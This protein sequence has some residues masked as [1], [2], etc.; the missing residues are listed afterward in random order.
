M[1]GLQLLMVIMDFGLLIMVTMM[2]LIMVVLLLDIGMLLQCINI[3]AR[4]HW[5]RMSSFGD[6]NAWRAYAGSKGESKPTPPKPTPKPQPKEEYYTVQSGRLSGEYHKVWNQF[7]RSLFIESSD[8]KSR[9]N[10]SRSES[11]G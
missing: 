2:V 9:P 5:I 7:N 3:Q 8:T 10:L 6:A 11:K 4:T 1:T